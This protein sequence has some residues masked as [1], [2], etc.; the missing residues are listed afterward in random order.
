MKPVSKLGWT[1][2]ALAL[3]VVAVDQAVKYWIVHVIDLA[4]RP[5]VP[6]LGPFHLS[7]VRNT[8]VSFGL[9]QGEAGLIRWALTAFSLIVAVVLIH[10]ARRPERAL[11]G[12]SLGLLIGGAIGNA[13]D[14]ARLGYVIDFLDFQRLGFFPWV[15]NVADS[16]I[17]IGIL[18]FLADAMRRDGVAQENGA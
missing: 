16:A 1:A 7:F 4:S 10:W 15:F 17:T 11:T 12:V 6:V 13:I 8:G 14:R 9:L 2:Y 3:A 18:M 5:T